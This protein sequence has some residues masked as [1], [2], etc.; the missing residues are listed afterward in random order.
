M[1][2]PRIAGRDGRDH[3]SLSRTRAGQRLARS[4]AIICVIGLTER[5]LPGVTGTTH[6]GVYAAFV[7]QYD[8]GRPK[9]EMLRSG[10]HDNAFYDNV[11]NTLRQVRPLGR[12]VHRRKNGELYVEL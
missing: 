10:Q 12:N 2:P 7:R 6:A 4:D 1:G 8:I 3:S 11:W 5:R 9:S